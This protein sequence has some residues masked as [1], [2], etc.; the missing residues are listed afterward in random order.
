VVGVVIGV[1]IA[2]FPVAAG[3]LLDQSAVADVFAERVHVEA[4]GIVGCAGDVGGGDDPC[5]GLV[6]EA[7][8]VRPHVAEPLDRDGRVREVSIEILEESFR[9]DGDAATGRLDAS[10]RAAD[11]Q[12]FPVTTCG[13]E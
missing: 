11:L 10:R 4:V 5:A 1:E 6:E 8:R 13:T 9:Y 7:G 2:R 3:V 12:R